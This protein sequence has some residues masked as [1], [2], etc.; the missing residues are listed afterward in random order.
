M[1]RI[2]FSIIAVLCLSASARAQ[3]ADPLTDAIN[4]V[5]AAYNLHSLVFDQNLANWAAQNNL[6]GFG[7]HV[8]GPAV[9][10]QNAAW[11]ITTIDGVIAGWMNSPGHRS[12]LL[13]PTI[14]ASGG[15]LD[16]NSVWTWNGGHALTPTA[17]VQPQPP[18]TPKT[19]IPGPPATV[20]PGIGPKIVPIP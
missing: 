8:M 9:V 4:R 13:D 18:P 19:T 5:R 11:G 16:G 15:A 20:I 1:R 12:A 7:H 2:M 17:Y 6:Y 10:R 14:T 3:T